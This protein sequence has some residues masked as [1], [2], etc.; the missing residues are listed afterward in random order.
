[1]KR[2]KPFNANKASTKLMEADG[3]TVQQVEYRIPH[4]FITKDC[5]GFADLLCC[6]PSRG[7]ML[8]QATGGASKSNFN[9]RV[10][11]VK[12]EPLHAIW[13]ASGGRIQVQSW[14]TVKGS[15]ERTVRILEITKETPAGNP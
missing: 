3:W 4:S 5:Y 6:S 8:V 1:M 7:I 11:K 12:A 14:E 9:A 10:A 2:K 13:L 15:K